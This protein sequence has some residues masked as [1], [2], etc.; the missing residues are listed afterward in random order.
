MPLPGPGAVTTTR[1]R[2][3]SMYSLLS[4]ALVA[5]NVLHIVGIAGDGIVTV[6]LY[7]Q[8]APDGVWNAS[9]AVWPVYWVMHHAAHVQAHAAE[10][11]DEPQHVQIVGDAQIA[12]HLVLLDV[13]RH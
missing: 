13:R 3:V 9:A 11:V 7:A 12:P 8:R 1:E 10:G 2:V 5:D 4:V 6:Y